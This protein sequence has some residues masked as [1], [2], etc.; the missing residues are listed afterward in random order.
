MWAVAALVV[1]SGC[2]TPDFIGKRY[3]NF[4]AYYNTFYNAERQFK[5]GYENLARFDQVV[6]R[7]QYL[8]LF[9]KTT[10]MSASREFEQTVLKSANLLREHPDSKWVDDALM[11]IGKSYFYQENYVGAIQKFSEVVAMDTGLADEA[12]FWYARALITSGSYEAALEELTLAMAEEDADDEW[13]AQDRLLLAELAIQQEQWDV[14]AGHLEAGIREVKDKELAARAS[15]LLGQVQETMGRFPE[16]VEAYRKVRDYPAPYELDYAARYSAARVDGRHVDPERALGEVRRLERDDKNVSKLGEI[17]FLRARILQEM[18]GFGEALDQ[19]HELLYDPLALPPGASAGNLRGRIH[20]ALGELY[21]DLAGDYVMAAAHF[22]SASATLASGSGRANAAR[23]ANTQEALKAPEAITDVAD[24]KS[25]F[26]TFSRVHGNIA[27]YDSL[28]YLGSLPD[29]AYAE[30]ILELRR[31]RAEELAEQQ[32]ILQ[33][34]QRD[35]AFRDGANQNDPMQNRGLQ[36]GKVIPTPDDPTGTASGFLLHKDPIRS[37]EGRIQFQSIW[38]NRPL[39]PNWRRSAALTNISSEESEEELA[40][41]EALLEQVANN[42]LPEIDD[43]AVPRDSTAKAAMRSSRAAARYELGNVLFLGMSRPDS[44][45]VWYRTVIEEDSDETVAPRAQ[46]ALAEVQ[47]ALG[48]SLSAV[49]LYRDL[50]DSYP[51]SDFIPNIRERLGLEDAYE[52]AADSS[53]LANMAFE[54][55]IVFRDAEPDRAIDSLLT[56]ASEWIGFPES[57]KAVFAVGSIHLEQAKADSAAIFAPIEYRVSRELLHPLWPDIFPLVDSTT[58]TVDTTGVDLMLS[59]S[60]GVLDGAAN[61]STRTVEPSAMDSLRKPAIGVSPDSLQVSEPGIDSDS[62]QVSEPGIDTDSLAQGVVSADSLGEETVTA[63]SLAQA[64]LIPEPPTN[65]GAA[66]DSTDN[67]ISPADSIMT[68]VAP[69]SSATEAPV[70][71]ERVL[72]IEDLL[73]YVVAKAG[74]SPLTERARILQ[75][76]LEE[77]KTPPP[78]PFDST[79]VAADSVALASDSTG[80][81]DMAVLSDSAGAQADSARANAGIEAGAPVKELDGGGADST[82]V[83]AEVPQ[84]ALPDSV[85]LAMVAQ[86]REKAKEE[87]ARREVPTP[88]RPANAGPELDDDEIRIVRDLKPLLPNGS[89]DPEARGY[90]FILGS[91][92]NLPAAQA[93]Y[94]RLRTTLDSTGVELYLLTNE[95]EERYQYMVGW[96]LFLE[97]EER[98]AAEMKWKGILPEPRN[99]LHLLPAEDRRP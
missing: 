36:P 66:P 5:S 74:V 1:I 68:G 7:E 51:D 55:A 4:T 23:S 25:S 18:G 92:P 14:A 32:R 29:S 57:P 97:K 21:R 81:P 38:G 27:R 42:Q 79:A 34:R 11:L 84:A 16:A 54:K 28:L 35:A 46:Y 60:T 88:G 6:D 48:D 17:R 2:K 24:L 89:T 53:S 26:S 15:F 72:R 73:G 30:K 94:R 87:E 56:V 91:Y 96:G 12:H 71:P 10:G 61:D 67:G 50:L 85:V 69:D 64:G 70:E 76:A 93:Q 82:G 40:E 39:V 75:A 49:R 63:D 99:L 20:Y 47:R 22:D 19:Y 95:G 52:V 3:N 62:L 31:L 58:T 90:T 8:P 65:A 59:D 83:S 77:L 41:Q 80:T 78:P 13:V 9:V 98:D 37:Q 43:S 44:A 45:A 33:E 86:A